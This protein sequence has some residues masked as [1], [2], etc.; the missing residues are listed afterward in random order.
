M[1]QTN[2][3][4]VLSIE[5]TVKSHLLRLDKVCGDSCSLHVSTLEPKPRQGE[6][7]SELSLEPGQ[8]VATTDIGK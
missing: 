1:V 4:N 5:S 7:K 6:E 3:F 2:R 8:E